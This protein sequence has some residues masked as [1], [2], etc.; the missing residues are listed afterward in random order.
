MGN[1]FIWFIENV[2]KES[3]VISNHSSGGLLAAW[4]AA[5]SPSNVNLKS[6]PI[7]NYAV[8]FFFAVLLT[9][10]PPG[11]TESAVTAN[12]LA[13]INTMIRKTVEKSK[14]PVT[15]IRLVQ[16]DQVECLLIFQ[17]FFAC[18]S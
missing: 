14:I 11:K 1:D 10:W 13:A 3:A 16:Q 4:L 15:S 12:S 18:R 8:F 6:K 5:Y 9:I 2:I 17:F 7:L